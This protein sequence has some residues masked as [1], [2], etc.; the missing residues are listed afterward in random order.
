MN[1]VESGTG[2]EGSNFSIFSYGGSGN[3]IGEYLSILRTTGFM[4]LGVRYP[5]A[6]LHVAG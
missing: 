5:A 4:G 3:Y 6:K 2:N 1:T